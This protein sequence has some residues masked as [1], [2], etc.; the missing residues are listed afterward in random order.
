M[1]KAR[2]RKARMMNLSLAAISL[3]AM[4][5]HA[6]AATRH[7]RPGRAAPKKTGAEEIV[8]GVS[9]ADGD[10]TE[11]SVVALYQRGEQGG[12]LCSA[13]LIG[14]DVALTAAHCV[15]DG[16]SERVVIFGT[17]V[18]A[19]AED[20]R[21]V[22]AAEIPS[23][24]KEPHR[25]DHDFGDIAVIRFEGSLPKG[26]KAARLAPRTL[27]LDKGDTVTLAGYGITS[28]RSRKGAGVLRKTQV[29]VIE[30][31]FGKTEMIFDQRD[32]TGACHGD[33]GGPAFVVHG[34]TSY[35]VG[36][37]NRSYPDGAP[38]NCKQEVVYTRVMAYRAWISS[39]V[40]D[41]HQR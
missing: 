36:V 17:D 6:G 7:R 31:E 15:S 14:K 23:L 24:W 40:A 10:A 18:R 35:L 12:A 28:A 13:T 8:G 37:T 29:S 32:G 1:R 22:V 2:M 27:T 25:E 5:L 41:L 26:F 20:A 21:R 16:P 9:V 3:L 39:A 4:P 19:D 33:S 38:D 11:R 30:P 34:K